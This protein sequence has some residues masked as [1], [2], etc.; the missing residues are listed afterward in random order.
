MMKS[1]EQASCK[2]WT[3]QKETHRKLQESGAEQK[4]LR[5]GRNREEVR[6][7]RQ[8]FEALKLIPPKLKW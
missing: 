1:P 8:K 3:L 4:K 5:E 7:E 6:R 2:A